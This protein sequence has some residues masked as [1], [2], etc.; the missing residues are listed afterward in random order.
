M[1]NKH[2]YLNNQKNQK[3]GFNR[4]RGFTKPKDD[5]EDQKVEPI[6]N[7][8]R[9]SG[10]RQD[11]NNFNQTYNN[12]YAKRSI[13]FPY[14]IDLVEISFLSIFSLDLKNKFY[15]KY[16]LLPLTYSDFNKTVRFEIDDDSLFQNFKNDLEYIISFNEDLRYSGENYNLIALIYQFSFIDKRR[17]TTETSDLII[18]TI[19]SNAI[20]TVSVQFEKLKSFL[21]SS[22]IEYT[23]NQ[24][25]DLIH[26]SEASDDIIT[27]IEDNFDIVQAITSSRVLKVRPGLFGTMHTEYGFNVE[28]SDNLQIVG[29]IDTGVNVLEPFTDLIVGNGINITNHNQHDANGHGTLVAGLAIFG[30]DLPASVQET[31]RAKCKV[32]PIKALHNGTD[33]INFPALIDAIKEANDKH[34]VRLFNMSLSF[35]HKN[36]N[37]TYSDFAFELDKLAYEFDILIFISV[38]NFDDEALVDLLTSNYHE[39]HDYPNFFY[40]LDATS[41]VHS[42]ETTNICT[43]SDSLNNISVGA[44]AGN[45][46]NE[47]YS[48]VTPFNIYPAYYSR[49]FNFDYEQEINKTKLKGNQKNKH[50]NKPDFIF[51]GGDLSSE[52]SGV[53]VLAND[54]IFF[55]RTTGTSLS[56]P[57][58]TSIAAEILSLYPELGTQ[59][60]KALLMNCAGYFES[61]D[62]PEFKGKSDLLKKL[63]GFGVPDKMKALFS[64]KN[65][66]TM[67][68]EDQIKPLEI[69]SIPIFLPEYLK[70][71]NNKLIF[72]IS[73]AY[74]FPPDKGNHLGYLPLHISFN[75][76]RNVPI[77]AFDGN[78]EDYMIKSVIS[79]SED[80]FGIENRL[81]SNAQKKEYRLQPKDIL[82]LDGEVAVAVRCLNKENIDES[83]KDILEKNSHPFSLVIEIKEEL[84]NET[85]RQLYNE[86]VAIND[87]NIIGEASADSDIDL[88]G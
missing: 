18:S 52:G 29:I 10:F 19:Q 44:L 37:E 65:T 62:L 69:L 33:G 73:L 30:T 13:E 32:L 12:R 11:Y 31:Y 45:L 70:K 46:K 42:C 8:F 68:I 56:T 78:K 63:I 67:V 79:W 1:P 41:P 24:T 40:K 53:E 86:I 71:S 81:F 83:L 51:D 43:P 88:D 39:D 6:I 35:H 80:H 5:N 23:L 58:I 85:N 7:Q 87:V 21:E 55:Q 27:I 64:N 28:I 25:E 54:G 9:I 2:V 4:K 36:Y 22:Q 66:I 61:K 48:D 76:V 57:L 34:G 47:D 74:S 75:L 77:S 84:K 50:L 16:G 20:E 72:N 14:Y 15:S 49:K 60:V 82:D 38:G 59:S 26:L 17:K 3:N